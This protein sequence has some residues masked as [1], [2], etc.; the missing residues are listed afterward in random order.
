MRHLIGH[1]PR[2]PR[3]MEELFLVLEVVLLLLVY[4]KR[5]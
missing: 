5:R 1:L 4:I 3:F 2:W